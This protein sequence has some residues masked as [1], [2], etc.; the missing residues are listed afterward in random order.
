MF[1]IK[2]CGIKDLATAASCVQSG[3]SAIGL[4]FYEKSKRCVSVETA[5]EI[6]AAVEGNI[7][8]VGLFVNHTLD[9]ICEVANAVGLDYLQFHGDESASILHGLDARPELEHVRVIRAI[10]LGRE[11]SVQALSE[12][13]RWTSA[14][15]SSRLASFILDTFQSGQ[16]GGTGLAIDWGWLSKIK[17]PTNVPVILAGGLEPQNVAEAIETVRPFGVDVAGGVENLKHQKDPA[18]IKAFVQ[19]A[20]LAFEKITD[21]CS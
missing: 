10:R 19:N 1:K 16:F 7:A 20:N 11:N 5:G 13:D 3:A 15:D 17:L 9:Q 18:L 12:I 6:A 14:N 2:I 4:N 8:V 21:E